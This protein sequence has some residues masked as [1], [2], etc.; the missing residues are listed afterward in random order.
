[1]N[2]IEYVNG[3][4]RS[5][6]P[7][8]PEMTARF[9]SADT[10]ALLKE[11]FRE[12]IVQAISLNR[13]KR[14]LFYGKPL[15]VESKEYQTGTVAPELGA[16][17]DE[18]LRLIHAAIGLFTEAGEFIQAIYEHLFTD[19]QGH[20]DVINLVE[21]AGDIFWYMAIFADDSSVTFEDIE[22]I[23]NNKLRARYP[24]KFTEAQ[25]TTRALDVERRVLADFCHQ[26]LDQESQQK[27]IH[28][29]QQY[30]GESGANEG[31]VE[32]LQR[33][34]K[35][36]D[37]LAEQ[38]RGNLEKLIMV[39]HEGCGGLVTGPINNLVCSECGKHVIL[40]VSEDNMLDELTGG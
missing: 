7:T 10:I 29:L 1:M 26:Q 40:H 22:R 4:L 36:R 24:E 30:C 23:N 8:T 31:A 14:H 37:N 20:L 21:E 18:S 28:I 12:C 32:T 11:E 13:F 19:G 39:F 2:N 38:F 27:I 34:I 9:H 25:A 3:A 15:E 16:K 17:L 33:I 6:S 5:E 35:E